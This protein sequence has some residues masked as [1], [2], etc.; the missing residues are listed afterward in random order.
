MTRDLADVFQDFLDDV[1][2]EEE[3]EPPVRTDDGGCWLLVGLVVAAVA[4][5]GLTAFL[6]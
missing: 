3:I 1:T 2:D 4:L 6:F 5:V